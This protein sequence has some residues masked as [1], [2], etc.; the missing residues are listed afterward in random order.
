MRP[1]YAPAGI[2]FVSHSFINKLLVNLI[3]YPRAAHTFTKNTTVFNGCK[4]AHVYFS[5]QYLHN[6]KIINARA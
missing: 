2:F 3:L 5:C 1:A 6:L 4:H